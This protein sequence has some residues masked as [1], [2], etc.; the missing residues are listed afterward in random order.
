MMMSTTQSQRF[1]LFATGLS[2]LLVLLHLGW[3]LTQGGIVS[4]HILNMPDLPAIS[5][6]W[7]VLILP[8]FTWFLS[9]FISNRL[10]QSPG[11]QTMTSK[12]VLAIL[13]G[14]LG[15]LIA[16]VL[17]SVAFTAGNEDGAFYVLV[18]ILLAALIFPVYRA[19]YLL[20]FVHGMMFTFG[21][22]LPMIVGLIIAAL[23]AALHH[24]VY[25]LVM[26]FWRKLKPVT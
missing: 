10:P 15:A 12:P 14:F 25:P 18:G 24:G 9:G 8:L 19:E 4:H 22:V 2:L 5:N 13:G 1:R 20:G 11:E 7:G 26:T 17:L 3:E 21:A 6:A 16:A 23:S